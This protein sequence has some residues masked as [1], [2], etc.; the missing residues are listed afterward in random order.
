MQVAAV[1]NGLVT[2]YASASYTVQGKAA[3]PSDVT[4]LTCAINCSTGAAS[5]LV[6][7]VPTVPATLTLGISSTPPP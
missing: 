2:T 4:G 3:P 5:V 7:S 6:V 1:L